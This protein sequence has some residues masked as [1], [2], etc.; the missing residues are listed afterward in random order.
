MNMRRNSRHSTM[1]RSKLLD[2]IT[3]EVIG[4]QLD[5]SERGLCIDSS[6]PYEQGSTHLLELMLPWKHND[7][8]SVTFEAIVRWCVLDDETG[9]YAIGLELVEPDEST[10]AVFGSIQEK[11]CLPS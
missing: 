8:G 5:I 4:S 10:L 3:K 11:H 2:A 6:T 1:F 7:L 9:K